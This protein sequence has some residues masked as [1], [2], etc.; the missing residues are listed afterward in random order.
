LL[1]S[2]ECGGRIVATGFAQR[3]QCKARSDNRIANRESTEKCGKKGKQ[4]R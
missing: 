2:V 1:R 4:R 3:E